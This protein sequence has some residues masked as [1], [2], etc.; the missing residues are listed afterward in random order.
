MKKT[1]G[2]KQI[3]NKVLGEIIREIRQE[4]NKR[5]AFPFWSNWMNWMNW[6]NWTNWNNWGNWRNW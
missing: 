4:K 2:K 6:M 3:Q 1:R 5:C